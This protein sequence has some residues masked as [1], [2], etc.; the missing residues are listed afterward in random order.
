MAAGVSVERTE[1]ITMRETVLGEPKSV[2]L[3]II[4][5]RTRSGTSA[6]R[7]GEEGM[8]DRAIFG[9]LKTDERGWPLIQ[10]VPEDEALKA[11]AEFLQDD[12]DILLP[13]CD[14]LLQTLESALVGGEEEHVWNGDRFL[15]RVGKDQTRLTDKYGVMIS[16]TPPVT[17]ETGLLAEIVRMWRE[18]VSD[19]PRQ[20]EFAAD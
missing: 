10:F 18:F 11:V 3:F 7:E 19:L 12:V 15:V 20:R 4:R 1:M 16:N 13:T 5:H 6:Q 9:K 17:I 14:E 2:A 8:P